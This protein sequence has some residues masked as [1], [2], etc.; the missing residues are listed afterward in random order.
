METVMRIGLMAASLVLLAAQTGSAV[1]GGHL[2]TPIIRAL[3]CASRAM[4]VLPGHVCGDVTAVLL[5]PASSFGLAMLDRHQAL[6]WQPVAAVPLPAVPVRR[7]AWQQHMTRVVAG[8]DDAFEGK[9][10]VTLP[11]VPAMLWP[12]GNPF[13]PR[14]AD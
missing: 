13:G 14:A 3:P 4:G 11:P 10:S 8:Y 1:A 6:R 12:G 2:A 5:G 7:R 9:A